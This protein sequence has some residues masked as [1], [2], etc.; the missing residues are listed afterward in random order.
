MDLRA[1]GLESSV[2]SLIIIMTE[3][4]R[5]TSIQAQLIS[6]KTQIPTKAMQKIQLQPQLPK[7]P[8]K[9]AKQANF[10]F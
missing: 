7:R 5:Q 2:D 4:H 8:F 10:I 1:D 6:Q 9:E 3:R